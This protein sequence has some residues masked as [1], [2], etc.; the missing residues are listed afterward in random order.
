MKKNHTKNN[1]LAHLIA[2]PCCGY[3]TLGSRADYDICCICWWEDDGADNLDAAHQGGPN[4]GISLAQARYNFLTYGIYDPK[5]TD[6][7]AKKSKKPCE[8]KRF[9]EIE[10]EY[11]VEKQA[12][13]QE[14][15][16]P[17]H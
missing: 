10:G 4:N 5:R 8:K 7:V 17:N 12:S 16:T 2:C 13:W 3:K 1:S 6:L 9:F 14:K 11:V 15:I